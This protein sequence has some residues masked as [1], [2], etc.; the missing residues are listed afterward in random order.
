MAAVMLPARWVIPFHSEPGPRGSAD[1]AYEVD[2]AEGAVIRDS[3]T[4]FIASRHF[5]LNNENS[6]RLRVAI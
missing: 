6:C 5:Y 2:G 1:F 4:D 3:V